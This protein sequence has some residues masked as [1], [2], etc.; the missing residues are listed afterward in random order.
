VS[1]ACRNVGQD[2]GLG[3]SAAMQIFDSGLSTR[4]IQAA[5]ST[6]SAQ[7]MM[8]VTTNPVDSIGRN[9]NSVKDVANADHNDDVTDRSSRDHVISTR[10][11]VPGT[12]ASGATTSSLAT[13]GHQ[14]IGRQTLTESQQLSRCVHS[15]SCRRLLL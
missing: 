5:P 4:G 8:S 14:H 9:G 3:P 13:A 12:S 6:P 11:L 2:H 10:V 15:I 1:S 7:V